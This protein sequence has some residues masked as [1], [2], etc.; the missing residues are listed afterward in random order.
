MI[1]PAVCDAAAQTWKNEAPD[2]GADAS[3]A[4]RVP[5]K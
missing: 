5:R 3:L 4:R 2:N 1:D